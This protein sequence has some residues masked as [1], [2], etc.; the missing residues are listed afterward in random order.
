ML[1]SL[2]PL[3][4]LGRYS[5]VSSLLLCMAECCCNIFRVSPSIIFNYAM[6]QSTTRNPY[7]SPGMVYELIASKMCLLESSLFRIIFNSLEYSFLSADLVVLSVVRLS[8]KSC[9]F[10]S[11][12]LVLHHYRV[13]CV[14]SKQFFNVQWW[15][16]YICQFR[17]SFQNHHWIYWRF[18]SLMEVDC[19]LQQRVE[20]RPWTRDVK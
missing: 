8:S 12:D 17:S 2:L 14:P 11:S 18:L 1:I 20:D 5:R 6:V 16:F 10:N 15:A 4:F 7:S 3:F 13:G 19:R 9:W